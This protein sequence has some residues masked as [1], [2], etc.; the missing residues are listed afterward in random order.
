MMATHNPVFTLSAIV[1]AVIVMAVHLI[2]IA[3]AWFYKQCQ[4]IDS[5]VEDLIRALDGD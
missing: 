5:S 1:V 2:A 3:C 4:S